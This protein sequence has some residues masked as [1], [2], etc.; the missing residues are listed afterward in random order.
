MLEEGHRL[1]EAGRRVLVGVVEDHGRADIRALAQGLR[2]VPRHVV[3]HRGVELAEMDLDAVLRAAPEVALV[4]ELAHTNAPGSRHVKRWQDVRELLGAGID[5]ISTVNIQHIESL[6]D[7]VEAITGTPQRE[8]IPDHVVCDADQVELVDLS[9]DMLRERL[10]EGKVYP[11]ERVDAALSHFFQVGTLTALRE[12][13]L[14]WLAD[15]VDDALRDYRREHHIDGT[16]ET[17]ER[18]V[19]ALVGGPEG[20]ALLRRGARIVAR[21]GGGELMAV[22]VNSPDGLR[23]SEPGRLTHQRE[24]VE[25]LGGTYHE[26]VDEDVPGALIAFA[27]SVEATQLVLGT[28]RRG[29]CTRPARW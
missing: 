20:D 8:T 9:P 15:D 4:D 25:K 24:L 18:V 1:Q 13:A 2:V 16:W 22:H 3:H 7:V 21:S 10:S 28:T 12:L 17:R 19:V 29:S 23:I 14:L 27:R 5:V 11:P 26:V 6:N